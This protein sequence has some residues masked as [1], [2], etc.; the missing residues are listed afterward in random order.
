MANQSAVP[1][2][3][4]N[5]ELVPGPS[6]PTIP[7][8]GPRKLIRPTLPENV[9]SRR[10]YSRR[11]APLLTHQQPVA[12]G[13]GESSHAE[14]FYLK[15][16]IQAQT[17]MVFILEGGDRLEG[18]IEWYDTDTIKVRNGHLRTLIYKAAVKYLY[19]ASDSLH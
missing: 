1:S 15:K 6:I 10:T 12:P 16:Q 8:S 17:Q 13:N 18:C 2:N 14:T 9:R 5:D 3:D 7:P 11:D 19:K 4:E